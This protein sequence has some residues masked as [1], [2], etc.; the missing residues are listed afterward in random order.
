[1]TIFAVALTLIGG[2]ALAFGV[3]GTYTKAGRTRYDEMD[4]MYPGASLC[5][6]IL[7]LLVAAVL[8]ILTFTRK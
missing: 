7:L 4:G 1:M 5:L 3:W 2:A 6:G 8:W